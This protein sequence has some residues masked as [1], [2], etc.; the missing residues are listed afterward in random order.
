MRVWSL[1]QDARTITP[2][3]V[4]N[5]VSPKNL[6]VGTMTAPELKICLSFPYSLSNALI[7][8]QHG[9]VFH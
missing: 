9:L 8:L 5:A 2:P 7:F 4:P 6:Y 1:G 3:Q